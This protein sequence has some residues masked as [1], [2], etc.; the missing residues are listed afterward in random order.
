M[1][2]IYAI[3]YGKNPLNGE[4]V[5]NKTTS[6]WDECLTYVKGVKGAK[7]KSFTKQSEVV[8][9]FKVNSKATKI[10]ATHKVDV[11]KGIYVFVD[12]SFNDKSMKTG[13]GA[14]LIVNGVV[15]MITSKDIDELNLG[16]LKDL[17]QTVGELVGAVIGVNTARQLGLKEITIIHDYEGVSGH[18]LGTWKRESDF[19]VAYYNV[20]RNT[21]KAG[22]D[23]KFAQ[24]NSHKADVSANLED[25]EIACRMFNSI[26]DD[27]AKKKIGIPSTGEVQKLLRFTEIKTSNDV[28]RNSL[29]ELG[30]NADKIKVVGGNI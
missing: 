13:A 29:I 7:Y 4:E 15:D 30:Y 28:I 25:Y 1:S 6:S 5:T 20:M 17:R 19:S 26:A 18:A 3:A 16:D 9:Y 8:D 11:N 24:I 2:K 10:G 21:M 23:V 27:L 12:G 22:V 14:I